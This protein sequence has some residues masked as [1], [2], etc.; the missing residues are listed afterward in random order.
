MMMAKRVSSM[1]SN[2]RDSTAHSRVTCNGEIRRRRARQLTSRVYGLVLMRKGDMS[3]TTSPKPERMV[4]IEFEDENYTYVSSRYK[5][6]QIKE[7]VETIK[8]RITL[9]MIP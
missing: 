8:K 2:G 6:R 4:S 9:T 3:R 5:W 7:D 1:R